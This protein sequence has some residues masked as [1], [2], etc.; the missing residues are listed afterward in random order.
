MAWC[1]CALFQIHKIVS[2]GFT[3]RNAERGI[4]LIINARANTNPS[5][6]IEESIVH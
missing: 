5:F 6:R 3:I 2:D 4:H 1:L